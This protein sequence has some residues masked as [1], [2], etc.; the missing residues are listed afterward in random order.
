MGLTTRISSCACGRVR[1][2]AIGEPILSAVCYCADCQEGGRRIEALPNA[3]LVR[4]PDGGTPYLT[5]RDD[6]FRCVSGADLLEE[7]RLKPNSPTRRMVAS[8]CNSGMFVKFDPGFWVSTYRLRYDGN[9]PPIEMRTQTRHR[10]SEMELPSDAPSYRGFP[11]RLFLKL[12][13]A[14]IAMLTG[15]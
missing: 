10:K 14:R 8:C 9:P 5:Y 13:A 1:C 7:H 11:L 2:E 12:G 6:R 4:D 3:A 15:H